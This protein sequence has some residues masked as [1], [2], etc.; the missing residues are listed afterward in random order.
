[1]TIMTIHLHRLIGF[2]LLLVGVG[3]EA[4]TSHS[5]PVASPSL[6]TTM[7]SLLPVP[8]PDFHRIEEAV[9]EHLRAAHAE[10]I[11]LQ[12]DP[13]ITGVV[14]G[15]AY[16]RLGQSY[17]AHRL[18]A[19]A[20]VCYRNAE[21]LLPKDIRWPYLSGYLHQQRVEL[22]DAVGDYRR[23]LA[24]HA[25]HAQA[26]LR[27]A[28][29]LLGLDRLDDAEALLK[30][31][32]GVP[33]FQGV[34]AFQLGKLMLRK[35]RHMEA[36]R[37]LTRAYEAH[38]DASAIHYPLAMAYRGQ[39]NI[40]A[41][42]HHLKQRGEVEPT[43]P[44]PVV[45]AL[46]ALSSGKRTHQYH[47]IRAVWRRQFDLAAR[48][49]EAI[50]ALD[51]SDISAWVSLGR[52][53]YLSDDPDGASQAFRI[54]LQQKPDHDKAN[55]FLGRLL[56]EQGHKDAAVSH[57][58]TTLKTDPGHGGAHFFLAESLMQKGEFQQAAHH[59][60]KV[61]EKLPEDLISRQ[62]ES[63]ALLAAGAAMH[64]KAWQRITEALVI[65]PDDAVLRRQLARLLTTSPD[66]QARDGKRGLTLAIGLFDEHN[67]IEHAELVAMAYAELGQFQQAIAYQ[68]ATLDTALQ[69]YG[70]Y[71]E[72]AL[73]ERLKTNLDTYSAEQPYR[74]RGN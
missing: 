13:E 6:A 61:Y 16:G 26:Q 25:D 56:W 73:L 5:S 49:Y 19:S 60:G 47:A 40:Q 32:S 41:A 20:E 59:F 11:S 27:L 12:A 36:V 64:K 52:C 67:T 62:R 9:K 24:L 8:M 15:E 34:A 37:L 43:I 53:R 72:P 23:T 3:V 10:V 17:H 29:V 65:H 74:D 69:Y 30:K 14:L 51:P 1:M 39:G 42:R 48:E 38:P 66:A 57:F 4:Q 21:R 44:D 70:P 50:L 28:Q 31:V 71:G 55:Y 22:A 33:E 54:V 68:Q 58:L 45:Q 35:G 7:N 63:A 2:L 46:S 18:D